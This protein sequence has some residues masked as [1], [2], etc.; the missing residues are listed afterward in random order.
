MFLTPYALPMHLFYHSPHYSLYYIPM[1]TL[2]NCIQRMF[3]V[4]CNDILTKQ[5]VMD[6]CTYMPTSEIFDKIN[7]IT[8]YKHGR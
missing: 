1:L 4:T 6:N 2:L 7:I 3:F 8:N 5:I